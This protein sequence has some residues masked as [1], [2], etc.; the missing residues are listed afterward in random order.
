MLVKILPTGKVK[1][2]QVGSE[3]VKK[4]P[5]T[6]CKAHSKLL[7]FYRVKDVLEVKSDIYD[8]NTERQKMIKE[9]S[10]QR[11]LQTLKLSSRQ[12]LGHKLERLKEHNVVT[13]IH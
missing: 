2:G 1:E 10:A 13:K 7:C 9:G 3:R 12:C 6:V 11:R 5:C 8:T 4:P